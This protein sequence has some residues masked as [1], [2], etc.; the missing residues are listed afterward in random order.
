MTG[1]SE[2]LPTILLSTLAGLG[3]LG[4]IGLGI[5]AFLERRTLSAT[6]EA[7]RAKGGNDDAT[8]ASIVAAAARELIDP[9]RRELA[10]ERAENIEEVRRERQM[11]RLLQD[12]LDKASQDVS[13][14]RATLRRA[15]SEVQE[16]KAL[17]AEKDRQIL[18]YEREIARLKEAARLN[19]DDG[20]A[21]GPHTP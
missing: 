6:A 20:L 10:T 1:V 8:A 12:E 4:G 3:L 19:R 16:T 21:S 17:I 5:K 11:V 18:L 14:L 13:T 9:L 2:F 7:T 15:M